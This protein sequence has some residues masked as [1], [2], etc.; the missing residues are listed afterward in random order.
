[1][2]DKTSGELVRQIPAE[3]VLHVSHN[4]ERMKGILFD[5]KS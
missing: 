5:S 4:I 1:V 2:T 3:E